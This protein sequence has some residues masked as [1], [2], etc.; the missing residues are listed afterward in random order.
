MGAERGSAFLLKIGNGASTPV[1]GTVAL[2]TAQWSI[3]GDVVNLAPKGSGGWHE[4]LTDKPVLDPTRRAMRS[5]SRCER[6]QSQFL[7]APGFKPV[8]RTASAHI[9]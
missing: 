3:N 2:Q 9:L 6:I 5:A 7:V 8:S 1:F 4:V